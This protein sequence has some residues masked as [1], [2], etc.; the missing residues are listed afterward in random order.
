MWEVVMKFSFSRRIL[1]AALVLG[2]L[3]AVGG[4]ARRGFSG[5]GQ[6]ADGRAAIAHAAIAR[7]TG[8]GRGG[9]RARATTPSSRDG[10]PGVAD[11]GG[12]SSV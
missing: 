6:G 12:G 7:E 9:E 8:H 10:T 3:A 1:L 4:R 2:L 5:R 11:T